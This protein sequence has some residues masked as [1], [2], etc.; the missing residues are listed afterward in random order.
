MVTW[1]ASR[2]LGIA[3]ALATGLLTVGVVYCQMHYAVDAVAGLAVGVVVAVAV[4]S[5]KSKK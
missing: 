4:N 1:S 3:L 2:R 5:V